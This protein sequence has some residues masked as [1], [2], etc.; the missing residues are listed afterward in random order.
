MVIKHS[1]PADSGGQMRLALLLHIKGLRMGRILNIPF[2]HKQSRGAEST[3]IDKVIEI[4]KFIASRSRRRFKLSKRICMLS[5]MEKEKL[6]R[7]IMIRKLQN[8]PK[9]C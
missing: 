6:A 5:D 4:E 3:G 9:K 2:K 1:L 8:Q 7:T